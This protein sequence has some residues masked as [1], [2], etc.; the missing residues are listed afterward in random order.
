MTDKKEKYILN[1]V[2]ELNEFLASYI[3]KH[4]FK[5]STRAEVQNIEELDYIIV[6]NVEQASSIATEYNVIK[7][8]I[9]I[10]CCED[11]RDVKDLLLANG[12]FLLNNNFTDSILTNYLLDKVF[13]EQFSIHLEENFS[14][15][16][17]N[18]QSF[19]ITNH[20]SMGLSL[21]E[22]ATNAFR[23]DYN[24][25]S[26]RSF[27]D[28]ITY[29]LSYL[30]QAGLAGI[31]FEVEYAANHE[32]FV[33]NIS[34]SVKNFVAEYMIDAFGEVKSEE[35]LN[36]LL[37]VAANT[38]DFLD[39][40]YLEEPGKIALTGFFQS[41]SKDKLKGITFNNILT[42]AQV[43][44]K[45]ERK[46]AN[47]IPETNRSEQLNN[48]AD[49]LASKKLP[50]GM[51]E[52]LESAPSDSI[53]SEDKDRTNEMI[54]F[55][56]EEFKAN[57]P[58]QDVKGFG[59]EQF[60]EY[61]PKFD[62]IDFADKL[63][64]EDQNFLVDRIKNNGLIQAY[65]EEVEKVRGEIVQDQAVMTS[66]QDVMGNEI[67]DRVAD[68]VDANI[69]N[70]ILNKDTAGKVE[71]FSS[72]KT[73]ENNFIPPMFA[74][75]DQT[76][77]IPKFTVDDAFD[78]IAP[79]FAA[80]DEFDASVAFGELSDGVAGAVESLASDPIDFDSEEFST[81]LPDFGADN[82]DDLLP[83]DPSTFPI[84]DYDIDQLAS[85]SEE[86]AFDHLTN[87]EG[88]APVAEDEFN[89]VGMKEEG[90]FSQAIGGSK[91]EADSNSL[92]KGG[93]EEAD[94]FM[95]KIS[96]LA[97]DDDGDFITTFSSSFEDKS[98]DDVFNFSSSS[99]EDS[100]GKMNMLV[101][102]TL[103]NNPAFDKLS[104]SVKSYVNKEAPA[105]INAGLE[106]FANSLGKTLDNF[107]SEDYQTFSGSEL[108]NI[109][110][111]LIC[112][113]ESI[114]EFKLDLENDFDDPKSRTRPPQEIS[115][116]EDKF[117]NKL[118]AKLQSIKNVEK[119]DDKFV[120]TDQSMSNDDMQV[121]IRDT[122]KETFE[123]EFK[124]S[125]ASPTEI[126]AKEGQLIK[127]LSQTLQM[128]EEDVSLIVKGA[129]Q[130]TKDKE[131]EIVAEKMF[132][133]DT[134]TDQSLD[135]NANSKYE[136]ILIQKLKDTEEENKKLKTNMSA[137]ELKL[138]ATDDVKDK[139]DK[140]MSDSQS[141]EEANKAI[142]AEV[143]NKVPAPAM[144]IMEKTKILADIKEGKNLD[145]ESVQK[146]QHSLE[147][148]NEVIELAKQAEM[149][150]KKAQLEAEKKDTLF[151]SELE[152]AEKAN[153][154]K[155]L[156]LDKAKI[157]MKTIVSKKEKDLVAL[158][159]QVNE[160]NKKL[161]DDQ[162]TQLKSQVNSLTKAKDT[163]TKTAELYKSKLENMAKNLDDKKKGE[164]TAVVA[165][166]NR[167]LKRVKNQLENKLNAEMK[168]KRS[169]EDRY[170]K[171]KHQETKAKN[172]FVKMS[173]EL[174]SNQGQLKLLKDQNTKLV[175]AASANGNL[176]ADKVSKELDTTK[177]NNDKLQLKIQDLNKRL[178]DAT[179]VKS[180]DGPA[181]PS[182]VK[183]EL[184]KSTKEI[185]HLKDQNQK[186]Q[187]KIEELGKKYKDTPVVSVDQ[188]AVA[189]AQESKDVVIGAKA[190][191]EV[192]ILKSQ[193]DQLQGKIKELIGKIKKAESANPSG[194][195]EAGSAKEERLAQSVKSMNLELSKA[196]LEVAEKKKENVKFKKD[197][198]GLKNQITQL[199]K[200]L[201]RSKKPGIGGAKKKKRAA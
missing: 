41:A 104:S 77:S 123:D 182:Q 97:D 144:N 197:T 124:F 136:S 10:I 38:C 117:K 181:S 190:G 33:I 87:I 143:N 133:G 173:T 128:D 189:Q 201:E 49:Q 156:V 7:N 154:T 1:L 35:P 92:V 185:D 48:A 60:Q 20:L 151:K 79:D 15:T 121:L 58:N 168:Q 70:Q 93:K 134:E 194:T 4:Q 132:S 149:A 195:Q 8:E 105:R 101:S 130:A 46:I 68:H 119:V 13:N 159:G 167:G 75:E 57:N 106:N 100:K 6:E 199:K 21:D 120:I 28:H 84:V 146:I 32:F 90:E 112:D 56:V 135:Q 37:G 65:D 115:E 19:K 171:S 47:F 196:R 145:A 179:K 2:E 12:R 51:I 140:I 31:P 98:K 73:I 14:E 177:K 122:M 126:E 172:D 169:L 54:N 80:P 67:A 116:F 36:Y 30:K 83:S 137:M 127:D 150:L 158:K 113:D 91:D 69:L 88:M 81:S 86:P 40:T 94:D 170:Q 129:G 44:I 157:A 141:P 3:E 175:Q 24:V 147:K 107:S 110:S 163:L 198:T 22:L 118:E 193:N 153:K 45:L 95:Q 114:E 161:K 74:K 109:M 138:S 102:S 66:L 23:G 71:E 183:H 76:P 78:S 152:R 96:G 142:E 184:D 43:D 25:V 72:S 99:T 50:G 174:K 108:P 16:L 180:I 61:A 178:D 64:T 9:Q 42:A 155:D 111:S 26:I 85:A 29:Y 164:N 176:K 187:N 131:K 34:A 139:F 17:D 186:L 53:L 63:T 18:I 5:L 162:S 165:E 192:E 188:S 62:D 166:E 191:K 52:L 82:F 55:M 125:N 89:V 200:E 148:E 11:T 103:D 39:I 59:L 27:V 160:L